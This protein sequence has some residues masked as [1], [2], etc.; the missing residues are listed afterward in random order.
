ML[1]FN[2]KAD[3]IITNSNCLTYDTK[4]FSIYQEAI[5]IDLKVT[6]VYRKNPCIFPFRNGNVTH[7]SCTRIDGKSPGY[8]YEE[9]FWC[10]TSV[11]ADLNWRTGGYCNDLCPLEGTFQALEEDHK[12][13]AK[14]PG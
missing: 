5:Y 10:A 7:N 14:Y 1:A 11:D 3:K 6:H 8:P 12:I 2:W 13:L 9:G 4:C